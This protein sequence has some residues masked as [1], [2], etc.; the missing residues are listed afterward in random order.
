[1]T[2]RRSEKDTSRDSPLIKEKPLMRYAK[3][4]SPWRLKVSLPPQLNYHAVRSM[5][6][7][8]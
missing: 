3:G 6:K 8:A 7:N 2:E 4:F 1:M 5:K